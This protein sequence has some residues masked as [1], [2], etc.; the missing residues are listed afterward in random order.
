MDLELNE[1][2]AVVA[3]IRKWSDDEREAEKK[4]KAKKR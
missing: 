2:A 3:F 4:A 1:K